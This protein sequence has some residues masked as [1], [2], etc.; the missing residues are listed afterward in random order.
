MNRDTVDWC[1]YWLGIG[2]IV[3][4][5]YAAMSSCVPVM[6]VGTPPCTGHPPACDYGDR[7]ICWCY[8]D[9]CKWYCVSDGSAA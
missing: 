3:G 8:K 9:K 2:F 7:P 4:C 1:T 6:P 5:L